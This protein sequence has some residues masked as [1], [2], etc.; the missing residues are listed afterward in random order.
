LTA[1][2]DKFI[3]EIGTD[4]NRVFGVGLSEGGYMAIRLA[5][6]APSRF[7]AVAPIEANLLPVESSKSD[8][9]CLHQLRLSQFFRPCAG[10]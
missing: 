4:R 6:E 2:A 1:L 10:T 8:S 3:G 5:L 7:R 9:L